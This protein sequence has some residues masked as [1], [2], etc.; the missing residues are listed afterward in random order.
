MSRRGLNTT[1]WSASA[2]SALKAVPALTNCVSFVASTER[3]WTTRVTTSGAWART[4]GDERENNQG[5]ET[6][7]F[8][9]GRSILSFAFHR[10]T[11]LMSRVTPKQSCTLV[12]PKGFEP[13]PFCAGGK[14]ATF[15]QP[16][17]LAFGRVFAC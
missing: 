9:Q 11:T 8:F 1:I 17:S 16:K 10:M 12:C 15:S 13:L 5:E 3:T 4:K 6:C 14:T 7:E 2:A